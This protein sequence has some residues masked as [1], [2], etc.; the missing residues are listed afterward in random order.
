MQHRPVV[1][2]LLAHVKT[3]PPRARRTAL[4]PH[5]TKSPIATRNVRRAQVPPALLVDRAQRRHR[6]RLLAVLPLHKLQ[7]CL[8]LRR[9]SAVQH[10]NAHAVARE[11]LTQ[12]PL[13]VST[14]R[15]QNPPS[16]VYGAH[17]RPTPARAAATSLLLPSSDERFV[18]VRSPARREENSSPPALALSQ[19]GRRQ[20]PTPRR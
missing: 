4:S 18:T 7:K 16:V 13:H 9:L 15:K 19:R 10:R 6:E 14:P 2:D 8:R 11:C 3:A 20:P 5:C 1:G 17:Q 12:R